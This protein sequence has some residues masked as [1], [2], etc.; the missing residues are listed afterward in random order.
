LDGHI[1]AVFS[2]NEKY[3][4]V[5]LPLEVK[6]ELT[7]SEILLLNEGKLLER[8]AISPEFPNIEFIRKSF[9]SM[10][11]NFNAKESMKVSFHNNAKRDLF[12]L[13]VRTCAAQA[14][15]VNPEQVLRGEEGE[16]EELMG[17]ERGME[18]RDN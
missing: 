4:G 18:E 17:E 11:F 10:L 13:V 3:A 9:N 6:I 15:A 2:Q 8:V 7:A 5:E 12:A 1:E 14:D 16:G